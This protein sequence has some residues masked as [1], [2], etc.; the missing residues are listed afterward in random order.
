VCSVDNHRHLL[1]LI[2]AQ[3]GGGERQQHDPHQ[4]K[5]VEQEQATVVTPYVVKDPMMSNPQRT[6]EPEADQEAVEVGPE[7]RKQC[8]RKIR[9]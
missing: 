1:V 7:F 9:V 5:Q 3:E 6:D 4:K 8:A 2:A